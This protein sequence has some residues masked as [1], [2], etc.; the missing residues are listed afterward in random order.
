[1]KS[2]RACE[3]QPDETT[4]LVKVRDWKFFSKERL[5]VN[6]IRTRKAGSVVYNATISSSVLFWS[7]KGKRLTFWIDFDLFVQPPL[8]SWS[9]S[10]SLLPI[11]NL[12]SSYDNGLTKIS[13]VYLKT[14]FKSTL[15]TWPNKLSQKKRKVYSLSI[16]LLFFLFLW[17]NNNTTQT[18]TK[19]NL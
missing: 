4:S 3:S 7:Q 12:I 11:W 5:F 6:R 15:E 17:I 18:T 1:M 14:L 2:E 10:L 9:P 8:V 19:R 16:F 13:L